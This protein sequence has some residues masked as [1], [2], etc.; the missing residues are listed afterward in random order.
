[1][2]LEYKRSVGENVIIEGLFYLDWLVD[3]MKVLV[4]DG[5]GILQAEHWIG[6][7]ATLQ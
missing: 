5:I 2:I 6:E 4:H 3:R 7:R 1:M